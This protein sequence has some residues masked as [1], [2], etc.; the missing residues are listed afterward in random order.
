MALD[1]LLKKGLLWSAL[2]VLVKRVFDFFVK[3]VLARLLFPEEFGVVGMAA[4]FTTFVQ[5]VSEM[6]IGAAL[7]Q[8]KKE[9]LKEIHF[10]T[11]FWFGFVWSVVLYLLVF[12][13]LTP[14]IADFYNEPI[15]LKVI[16]ILS[17]PILISSINN[18]NK[19]QLM[20]ELDFKKLAIVNNSSSIIAGVGAILLA[21]NDFGIW[22]LVFNAV[23]PF[24]VAIPLLFYATKWVPKLVWDRVAFKEIFSFGIY[25]FGTALILNIAANIDYLVIGKLVD[26]AALGAYT[27]AFMLTGLVSSQITSM[28]NRVMFPFYSSIQSNINNVKSYYLKVVG[29]SALLIYPIMLSLIVLAGPILSMLFGD[30]WVDTKVP[31]RI[32]SVAVLVNVFTSSYNLLYRS[33]GRPR[34]EMKILFCMLIFVIIPSITIG[35]YYYDVRGVAYGILLAS[36]INFVVVSILLY[37]HFNIRLI[38]IVKQLMPSIIAFILTF[39]IIT[40]LY[41]YTEIHSIILL[42]FLFVVFY[43]ICYLFYKKEVKNIFKKFI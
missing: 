34:L 36:I 32:L 42:V 19:A 11:A 30:K 10:Q 38:T 16:P 33:L 22:A 2:E 31:L 14:L 7:I 4:V 29:Y 8:R 41:L 17:L 37:R 5:V 21:V 26:A 9:E 43:S 28:L 23:V 20:R 3:L 25:T 40:S 27:L 1:K 39:Y 35:G 13:V 12:F 18:V 6:G 15:L 24:F